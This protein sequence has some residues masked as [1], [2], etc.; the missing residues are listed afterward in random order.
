MTERKGE[1][2][3]ESESIIRW[4]RMSGREQEEEL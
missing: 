4:D 1:S 2:A 3:K